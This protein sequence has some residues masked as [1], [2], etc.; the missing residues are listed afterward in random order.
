[1][2]TLANMLFNNNTK[3][4]NVQTKIIRMNNI[5]FFVILLKIFANQLEKKFYNYF[6]ETGYFHQEQ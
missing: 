4:E 2:P 6:V 3:I 1:M 5:K